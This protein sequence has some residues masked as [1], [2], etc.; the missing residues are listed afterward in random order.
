MKTFCRFSVRFQS[1]SSEKLNLVNHIVKKERLCK[2][3]TAS[4]LYE[5]A[6]WRIVS[7]FTCSVC[8]PLSLCR[9]CRW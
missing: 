4:P 2:I 8:A 3:C 1:Q 7:D 5:F 6:G 9:L